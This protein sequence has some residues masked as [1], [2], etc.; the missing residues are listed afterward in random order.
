MVRVYCFFL[1]EKSVL[2]LGGFVIC[3]VEDCLIKDAMVFW[4]AVISRTGG[5][6]FICMD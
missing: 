4:A 6:V 5:G 3:S 2:C 1:C